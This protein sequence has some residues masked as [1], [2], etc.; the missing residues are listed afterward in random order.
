MF[1]QQKYG[2]VNLKYV[3]NYCNN[4]SE[5]LTTSFVPNLNSAVSNNGAF[6]EA[7]LKDLLVG[8]IR[9]SYHPE[10]N[11]PFLI[12]K[13]SFLFHFEKLLSIIYVQLS[14][15]PEEFLND[16]FISVLCRESFISPRM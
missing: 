8:K 9:S 13:V 7:G 3:F 16:C 1:F 12:V 11:Q 10:R 5:K 6:L 15:V 4:S 14:F 2:F